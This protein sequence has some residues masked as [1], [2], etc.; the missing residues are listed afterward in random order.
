MGVISC[1]AA[2]RST[3]VGSTRF[4]FAGPVSPRASVENQSAI[5]IQ[6]PPGNRF[7]TDANSRAGLVVLCSASITTMPSVSNSVEAKSSPSTSV[8]EMFVRWTRSTS[9]ASSSKTVWSPSSATTLPSYTYLA[10]GIVRPS[11]LAPKTATCWD[12]CIGNSEMMAWGSI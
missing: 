6:P 9:D 2:H 3:R 4:D 11:T 10:I 1:S 5:N 7:A 12:R 8:G